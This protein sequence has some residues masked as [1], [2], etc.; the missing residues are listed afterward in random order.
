MRPLC[1]LPNEATPAGEQMV[2]INSHTLF[3]RRVLDKK[4]AVLCLFC[5]LLFHWMR[6]ESFD[7]DC[8]MPDPYRVLRKNPDKPPFPVSSS[9]GHGCPIKSTFAKKAR[10]G[11]R[12]LVNKSP[13][14]SCNAIAIT[15][16]VQRVLSS[17]IYMRPEFGP[18]VAI[19]HGWKENVCLSKKYLLSSGEDKRVCF[20]LDHDGHN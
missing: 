18:T 12:V 11:G 20:E 6:V 2:F 1:V 5:I 3:D 7:T 8:P 14:R 17:V 4:R 13:C 9:C 15:V 16:I 10:G 19:C